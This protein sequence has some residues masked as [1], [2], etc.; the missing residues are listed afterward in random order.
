MDKQWDNELL[1]LLERPQD[2]NPVKNDGL[3]LLSTSFPE[4]LIIPGD[5]LASGPVSPKKWEA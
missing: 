5:Y 3:E 1:R 4:L 2:L